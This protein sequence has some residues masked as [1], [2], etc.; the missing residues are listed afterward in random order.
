MKGSNHSR[1]K[2]SLELVQIDVQAS[3]ETKGSSDARDDL[4]NDSVQVGESRGRDA[5]VFLADFV[6]SLVIDLRD[7]SQEGMSLSTYARAE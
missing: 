1:D 7:K 3:I 6:D 5:E 4:G 2:V